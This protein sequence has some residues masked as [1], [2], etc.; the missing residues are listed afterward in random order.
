VIGIGIRSPRWKGVLID[1]R[2]AEVP[3]G[4]PWAALDQLRH[5]VHHGMRDRDHGREQVEHVAGHPHPD[6]L[7]SDGDEAVKDLL[8]DLRR[9]DGIQGILSDR[10]HDPLR[11]RPERMSATGGVHQHRGIEEDRHQRGPRERVG[12]PT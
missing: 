1:G 6:L 3:G 5:P 7:P 11:R 4:E 8:H 10:L 9:R 12:D 2:V